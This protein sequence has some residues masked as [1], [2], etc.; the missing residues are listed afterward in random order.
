MISSRREIEIG[1]VVLGDRVEILSG[2]KP[3]EIV[4]AAGIYQ[5]EEGA[6]V[7]RY[8]ALAAGER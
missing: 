8:T 6:K 1:Q 4:A 5:L 2:L 7:K 3:G